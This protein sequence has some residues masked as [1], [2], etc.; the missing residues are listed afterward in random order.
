MTLIEK[1]IC[2]LLTMKS[3]DMNNSVHLKSILTVSEVLIKYKELSVVLSPVLR[4]YL[5]P[6]SDILTVKLI[7]MMSYLK[8]VGKIKTLLDIADLS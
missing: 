2:K 1:D 6:V 7:N 5:L 4:D 8:T 3:S